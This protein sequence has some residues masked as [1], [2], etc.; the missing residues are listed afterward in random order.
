MAIDRNRATCFTRLREWRL[1]QVEQ[2]QDQAR[3]P[4]KRGICV[5]VVCCVAVH[6]LSCFE[7]IVS[8][9]QGCVIC[10]PW[11]LRRLE[12]KYVTFSIERMPTPWTVVLG[13]MGSESRAG[14]GC[15]GDAGGVRMLLTSIIG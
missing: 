4:G 10:L 9:P 12:K 11:L 15:S 13:S 6:N 1:L 8:F 2:R 5:R 7:P 14:F 3:P